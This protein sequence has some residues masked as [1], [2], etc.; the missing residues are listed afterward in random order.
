MKRIIAIAIIGC[1]S[2]ILGGFLYNT[3]ASP[4]LV[5]ARAEQQANAKIVDYVAAKAE[6][7][8]FIKASKI[9]TP[10]VVFIKCLSAAQQQDDWYS[11]WGFFGNRGPVS[12]SGSG[13]IISKDGYIVTNYHVIKDAQTIDVILNGN[14]RTFNAKVIGIDPNSDLALLKI[15]AKDLIAVT[16]GNSENVQ[17]G[18]WVLAVGNPFN[19]TSTVT[20]GIVSA[21]GRNINVNSN[22]QF[23]IESFIQTDA[24]INPGNSGG[25]LVNLNGEL[26][27]INTAIQSP[28]GAYAGYGF[29]IPSNMV[30]KIVKD[31]IEYGEVQKGFTGMDVNDLD[32][33]TA[34]KLNA[35]EG[36]VVA[37]LYEDGPAAKANIKVNDIITQVDGKLIESKANF[38]EQ[39]SYHRPGE[40]VKMM[41]NRGGK[42]IT[43]E[44]VLINKEGNTAITRKNT[45]TSTRLGADFQPISKIERDK[46]GV[47]SGVRLSNIK[48]GMIRQMGLPEGFVIYKLNGKEYE[49]AQEMINA[50]EKVSGR[51]IIEGFYP[52]G[53][54]ATYSFYTY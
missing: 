43:T 50:L 23:P 45:V 22:A 17:T 14:K 44:L 5:I 31:L 13:V 36:V 34:E 3:F 39:I 15:E 37:D 8:D 51:I 1:F 49:D 20:A 47:K 52:N 9:S 2:G 32:A 10:A 4:K 48:G 18:E 46:L 29:A 53:S 16:F 26:I 40:K 27:G 28:T 30:A 6:A 33:S 25:A 12:S 35:T 38:D 41:L 24:A 42:S 11:F 19:L 21:K 54:K 7:V